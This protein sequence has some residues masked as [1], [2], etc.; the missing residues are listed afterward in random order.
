MNENPQ[1][2]APFLSLRWILLAGYAVAGIVPLL[3]LYIIFQNKIISG[4][5]FSSGLKG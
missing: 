2:K 5:S 4:I 3:L 1:K